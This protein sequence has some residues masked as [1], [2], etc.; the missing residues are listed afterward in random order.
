MRPGEVE[1]GAAADWL[2]RRNDGGVQELAEVETLSELLAPAV[3]RKLKL[4]R[5]LPDTTMRDALCG[6]SSDELRACLARVV[7]AAWR[8]KA[9]EP[10][11]LPF[12]VV[13]M[14]G[15]ATSVPHWD[16]KDGFVQKHQP[17]IGEPYGLARTVT[18]TLVSAAGRPCIDAIPIPSA[19]NEMGNFETA[20]KSLV[21]TYGPLFRVITYDAGA[22][23]EANGRLV[24]ESN[25]AY[26]LRLKGEQRYMYKLAT[27]LID[28]HDVVGETVDVLD[29]RTTVTR[30]VVLLTA[31]NFAY[32]DGRARRKLC[33][34]TYGRSSASSL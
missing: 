13:A 1:A 8:R 16:D 5:R 11:G 15:K 9:L 14:D 33:G 7:N 26:L 2:P 17:E 30:K 18:C 12:G 3:R 20:F 6:L 10:V 29:N 31:L 25:K 19:T 21:A 23:S 24:V 34:D 27:E 32:G 28:P 4:G 22:L